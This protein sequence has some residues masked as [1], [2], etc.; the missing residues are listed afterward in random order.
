MLLGYPSLSFSGVK[1][2]DNE[3]SGY[4]IQTQ[5]EKDIELRKSGLDLHYA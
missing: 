5:N 2:S 4:N 1:H 3:C